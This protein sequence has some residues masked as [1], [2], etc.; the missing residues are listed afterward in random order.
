M[1]ARILDER[2]DDRGTCFLCRAS[3]SDYIASVPATYQ[4]Y[5][6]QREI[7]TNVYLDRLVETVLKRRHIPIIVLVAEAADYTVSQDRSTL[8]LSNYK[9][10]DG[11]Q[12]TFRL[13]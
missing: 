8:Q 9:I 4:Q 3:L 6:I 10:L 11:L 2:T 7:V 12:R 5:D 13:K 1:D